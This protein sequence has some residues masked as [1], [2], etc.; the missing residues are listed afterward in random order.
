[1]SVFKRIL[2]ITTVLPLAAVGIVAGYIW[3]A[4]KDGFDSAED[5][6]DWMRD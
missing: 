5:I 4:F 2:G 6:I 3:F 1:M